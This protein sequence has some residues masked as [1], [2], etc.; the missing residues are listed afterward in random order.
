[1]IDFPER[2]HDDRTSQTECHYIKLRSRCLTKTPKK[3]L[4]DKNCWQCFKTPDYPSIA[5]KG[6]TPLRLVVIQVVRE[7]KSIRVVVSDYKYIKI[8]SKKILFSCFH[9]NP[10][11][12]VLFKE[13]EDLF[14][15]SECW[16]IYVQATS[17]L[18]KRLRKTKHTSQ[19]KENSSCVWR[20]RACWTGFLDYQDVNVD[21]DFP[22]A[23][24][25]RIKCEKSIIFSPTSAPIPP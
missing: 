12:N 22:D 20:K 1:M 13:T 17:Y 3:T 15:E 14:C 16:F 2:K 21:V 23:P 9:P 8:K 25:P 7:R 24:I 19:M 5:P 10:L 4:I 18:K 11:K 6:T